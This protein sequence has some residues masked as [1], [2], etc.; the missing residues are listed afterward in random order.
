MALARKEAL[1]HELKPD[2]LDDH[3]QTNFFVK[4]T[5]KLRRWLPFLLMGTVLGYLILVPLALLVIGSFK[6]EGLVLD[7]GFTIN[8]Y[9]NVYFTHDFFQLLRA[10]LTFAIGAT[11]TALFFGI[12][13]AW[14]VERTDLPLRGLVRALIIL[15]MATPPVLLAIGWTMLLSPRIGFFN[16]IIKALFGL[17]E[18][19]LN[20]FSFPG[21]ILVEGLSL[22]PST[23]LILSPTF[24]NMDPSLEEAAI[25]SG[26][27]PWRVIRRIIIPMVAPAILAAAAFL[28]IVCFVVF[29]I[30]GTLGLPAR[31]YLF[32]SKI[33]YMAHHSETGLPLYGQ[34]AALAMFFLAI[35]FMLGFIYQRLTQQAQRFVTIT[36]RGYRSRPF[37][38]GKLRY[39]ALGFVCLYFFL[40]VLAPLSILLWTSLM[41]YQA[42]VSAEALSLVTLNNHIEF[43]NNRSAFQAARNSVTIAMVSATAVAVLSMLVAWVVVRSDTVGRRIIDLLS[44]VPVAIP[45]VLTG[46]ALSYVYLT[47]RAVPVYGTIW[48]IA[49]SYITYYSSYGT[50]TTRG[51]MLQ[52]HPELEEAG[53]VSGASWSFLMRKI[54]IPLI[55]PGMVAVWIWVVAHAMR[56]LSAALMLQGLDN[57]VL[58]TLL[59]EYWTGGEPNKAAAVGVWL[60]VAL[61]VVV[62]AWHLSAHRNKMY[63]QS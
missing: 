5:G 56:E 27:G 18:A 10:T 46:V 29:D 53:S 19:P 45:G 43:L 57:P 59:W 16:E 13:L 23:F 48:I 54:T 61:V 40:G 50:R 58:S 9:V 47:I 37:F 7:P 32:S 17:S 1:S 31:I 34:I 22:T 28:I 52:M 49:I 24:R 39:P 33:Y 11:L 12:T 25:T 14:L 15:P 51:V 8:N 35:L 26:A 63:T 30:P 55:W 60:M 44:F 38:L 3:Q 20:V 36:G 6:P 62:T 4:H 41:P 2:M 21:M 42:K